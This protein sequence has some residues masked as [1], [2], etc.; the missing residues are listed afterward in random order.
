MSIH[1]KMFM[2]IPFIVSSDD[3]FLYFAVCFDEWHPEF[4]TLCQNLSSKTFEDWMQYSGPNICVTSL[5]R[6]AILNRS[7]CECENSVA[8]T[9]INAIW[10]DGFR[11]IEWNQQYSRHA[12]N[13]L[14]LILALLFSHAIWT[15]FHDYFSLRII[16]WLNFA[17]IWKCELILFRAL[18]MLLFCDSAKLNSHCLLPV[19]VFFAVLPRVNILFS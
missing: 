17:H 12:W 6:T 14:N 4:M 18:F 5:G 9:V 3:S 19:I 15:F 16:T 11:I 1:M 8:Y 2:H 13:L 7:S 10:T